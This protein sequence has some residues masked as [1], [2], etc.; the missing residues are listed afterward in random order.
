MQ[1]LSQPTKQGILLHFQNIRD[2]VK[3]LDPKQLA[4]LVCQ[5]SVLSLLSL[6]PVAGNVPSPYPP[7]CRQQKLKLSRGD[8]PQLS[9]SSLHFMAY[10]H[11][12]CI[13]LVKDCNW[14]LWNKLSGLFGVRYRMSGVGDG[15]TKENFNKQDKGWENRS[16]KDLK[17]QYVS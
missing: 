15:N 4:E 11:L 3:R 17:R 5:Q 8:I 13:L 6:Q 16:W 7:R 10:L 9:S 1:L 2:I 12:S 14:V